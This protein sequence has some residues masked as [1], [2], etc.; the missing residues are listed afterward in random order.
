DGHAA[1]A[2]SAALNVAGI[3]RNTQNP[4]GGEIL[5]NKQTGEPTGML[6]DHAEELVGKSIPKPT[7]AER[8]QAFLLGVNREIALGWCQIQNAGSDPADVTLI[9]SAFEK[10]K[11]KLRIYN[12]VYGPGP[13]AETLLRDG[14]T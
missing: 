6:L 4:F 13:A 1:I 10:G 12:A 9:R 5:K 7:V 2:N 8:E 11:V 3:D 14:M